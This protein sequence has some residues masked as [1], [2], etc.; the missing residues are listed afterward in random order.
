[1]SYFEKIYAVVSRV[2]KGRVITYKQ[3]AE[4]AQVK[5][6]R[7][8]GNALH[9]NKNPKEIPCH[10]VIKKD[11]SLAKGYAF[12]GVRKQK[13]LLQKEGIPFNRDKIDIEKYIYRASDN[14]MC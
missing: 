11:G 7:I 14:V 3:V 6:P 1:M 9:R 4:A 8:V 2:P 10:R 13:E 12:G 5:N